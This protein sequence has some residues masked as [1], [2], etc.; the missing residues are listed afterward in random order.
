MLAL[1]LWSALLVSTRAEAE[2]S[3][4]SW[5]SKPSAQRAFEAESFSGGVSLL[6]VGP[7]EVVRAQRSADAV[8]SR[9]PSSPSKDVTSSN[10]LVQLYRDLVEE[11]EVTP[12]EVS[13]V[14]MLLGIVIACLCWAPPISSPAMNKEAVPDILPPVTDKAPRRPSTPRNLKLDVKACTSPREATGTSYCTACPVMS[15]LGDFRLFRWIL[16]CHPERGRHIDPVKPLCPKDV[17]PRAEKDV[18]AL[19]YASP[20]QTSVLMPLHMVDD[21]DSCLA[22]KAAPIKRHFEENVLSFVVQAVIA[23]TDKSVLQLAGT[24]HTRM[25]EPMLKGA[26]LQS[27]MLSEDLTKTA[28]LQ[29][30]LAQPRQLW[31]STAQLM[32]RRQLPA[33]AEEGPVL[34]DDPSLHL[35]ARYIAYRSEDADAECRGHSRGF[36]ALGADAGCRT[37]LAPFSLDN[38]LAAQEKHMQLLSEV[39]SAAGLDGGQVRLYLSY[40][41]SLAS[42]ATL[43]QLRSQKGV[44]LQV[45]FNTW[46]ETRMWTSEL[47]ELQNTMAPTRVMR[48]GAMKSVLDADSLKRDLQ[49]KLQR[50]VQEERIAQ[51]RAN[52][53]DQPATLRP[54]EVGEVLHDDMPNVLPKWMREGLRPR[55]A[56]AAPGALEDNDNFSLG[57]RGHPNKC[58][59]ACRFHRRR[60]GCR[61]GASC[62]FCHECVFSDSDPNYLGVP[63]HSLGP[64]SSINAPV[65]PGAMQ[66]PS[67]EGDYPSIGSIG[68]PFSCGPPCKYNSKPKG[69]KDGLLCDHCHLCRWKR[70]TAGA[71]PVPG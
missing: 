36:V 8:P 63:L 20:P 24:T 10:A 69:C 71:G 14:I 17:I 5:C 61:E 3:W 56:M 54:L 35:Q 43:Y 67:S 41:P 12:G 22:S 27:V 1:G 18:Q 64:A 37:W 9:R 44:Q 32:V 33:D 38:G 7:A 21:S 68:H 55:V 51:H 6:Q 29:L 60:G 39:V 15:H 19:G 48:R 45:A 66:R 50:L 62:K 59:P 47:H 70:H 26:Q 31:M 28:L 52:V 65:P 23:E 58:K 16:R 57:T 49:A 46:R 40:V 53:D 34:L 2:F 30:Q 42:L 13:G 25:A 4:W 11:Q